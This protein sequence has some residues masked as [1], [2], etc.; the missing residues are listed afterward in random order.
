[1]QLR[2]LFAGVLALCALEPATAQQTP[3]TAPS[4][5]LGQS[6]AQKLAQE[7]PLTEAQI[8]ERLSR[9]YR[10][11]SDILLAEARGDGEA[12]DA[13]FE[14]AMTE[15]GRLASQEGIMESSVGG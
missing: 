15:L 11:Q 2:Y 3:R 1:M 6:D 5:A 12:V 7:G 13:L 14:L 4:S 9:L 8:L 10:Y